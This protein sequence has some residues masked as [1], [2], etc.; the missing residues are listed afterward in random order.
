MARVSLILPVAPDATPGRERTVPYRDALEDQGHQVELIWVADPRGVLP[1]APPEGS[2]RALVA[3]RSGMAV[4]TVLGL[5]E[6]QGEILVVLDLDRGYGP[7]EVVRV[8]DPLLRGEAEFAVASRS[9]ERGFWGGP[10]A[11]SGTL[12]RGF[13]GTSDP[14]SGLVAL[15]R[16]AVP[17]TNGPHA[18]VGSQFTLELLARAVGKRIDVPVERRSRARPSRFELDDVRHFK[19][20]ADH[21][22]GNASR[23]IQ[24]CL[25]GASGM[26]VDLTSY[27]LFQW[28]F[29]KT[30]L[31]RMP[32]PWAGG[33]W[34]LAA[35]GALAIG[36]A[37]IW[38]F[39][40]NR[41][42]TFNDVRGGSRVRQFATYVLSNALAIALSFTLRMVLPL[43]V[44][45]FNRHKLA[46][47]LV[48]IVAATGISFSMSRWVVFSR[49]RGATVERSAS[50][51][52]DP[53]MS[54]PTPIY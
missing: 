5:R 26:V 45:F 7:R 20:L 23:L 32:A 30:P 27:A 34:D 18:P 39:S 40:L 50:V 10:T 15:T 44:G 48:G 29:S 6:A 41:R 21:R 16:H 36:L 14:S 22:F 42:L 19:R 37:L 25:V 51:S 12:A 8:I 4:A 1:A 3:Q 35:A 43:R 13:L 17:E 2:E 11:W 54:E 28:L 52:N 38:N 47:A 33:A 46:A 31:T 49:R 9:G 24:F 53:A